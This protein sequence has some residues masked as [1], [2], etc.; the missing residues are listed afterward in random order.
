[1]SQI[2]CELKMRLPGGQAARRLGTVLGVPLA[3]LEQVNLYLETTDGQVASGR[4][5]V[6]LRREEGRWTLTYKRG[7]QV[8]AG[9]FEAREVEALL[10]AS[11]EAEWSEAD[12]PGLESL[13]PLRALRA[14]GVL[15][16]LSVSGEVYNLRA[17]YR[18]SNGDILELDRTRFPGGRED[19]EVEVETR[20]PEEVRA[21]LTDLF[22]RAGVALEEQRQTK[23]ERFL[24]AISPS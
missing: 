22:D 12:L 11:P 19:W 17:R 21:L 9:Y 13:A 8:Q 5:M 3:T 4:S 24:E 18:L 7:L 16:E 2:E 1:M 14:D 15:G 6:R 20:R 23:Y 10:G